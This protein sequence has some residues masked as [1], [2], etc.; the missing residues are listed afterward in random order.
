MKKIK[1]LI[2]KK[3]LVVDDQRMT[4]NSIALCIVLIREPHTLV[5]VKNGIG[6]PKEDMT[7]LSSYEWCRGFASPDIYIY[8][9]LW[10]L[11]CEVP[12][13]YRSLRSRWIGPIGPGN[14]CSGI[15]NPQT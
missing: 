2:E 6:E 13:L 4:L 14:V 9:P 12:R 3:S 8:L 10:L 15:A 11:E 7:F 5:C 1:A